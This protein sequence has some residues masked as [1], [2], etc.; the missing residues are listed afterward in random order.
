MFI[1][2]SFRNFFERVEKRIREWK[3]ENE[4]QGEQAPA[5]HTKYQIDNIA[6]TPNIHFFWRAVQWS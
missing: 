6:H 5:Q 3:R 2:I 4:K 1:T